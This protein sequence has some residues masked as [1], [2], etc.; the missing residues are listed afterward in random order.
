VIC[1]RYRNVYIKV[2]LYMIFSSLHRARCEAAVCIRYYH[3]ITRS[4]SA[5]VA[6]RRKEV[7]VVEEKKRTVRDR[8]DR[9][10]KGRTAPSQKP[11]EQRC[12]CF[13]HRRPAGE[14]RGPCEQSDRQSHH[15][16]NHQHSR[17]ICILRM[18]SWRVFRRGRR[19]G[20]IPTG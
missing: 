4:P 7:P 16:Q 19:R 18:W 20:F 5:A 8:K 14:R 13:F 3:S 10:N 9:K 6:W 15:H 17:H 1:S 12:P 11:A 2:I